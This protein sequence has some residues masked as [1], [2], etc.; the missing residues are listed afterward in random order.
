MRPQ[1]IS[2]Q[3]TKSTILCALFVALITIC[4]WISIPS[5]VPFTLQTFAVFLTAGLLGTKR[6]LAA[7]ICYILIGSIGVPVFANFQG[8]FAVIAGPLG[9]YIIGFVFTALIAGIVIDRFKNSTLAAASGMVLGLIAC[10][11][12]GTVWFTYIYTGALTWAGIAASLS[13]CV[14]PF[15]IPD[16]IKISLAVL[17][18]KRLKKH[19][20][21]V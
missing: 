17:L 2:S 13:M 9:G 10:Y 21:R 5:A 19:I 20:D 4:S 16:I 12:F 14:I 18:T 7:I 1:T 8:G 3:R 15:I 6:S 11:A